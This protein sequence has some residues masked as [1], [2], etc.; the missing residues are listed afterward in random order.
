MEGAHLLVKGNNGL[1]QLSGIQ[2]MISVTPEDRA[3]KL[4]ANQL[5]NPNLVIWRADHLS[6][7]F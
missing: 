1:T 4:Q 3:Q 7:S 2:F 5:Q 6:D